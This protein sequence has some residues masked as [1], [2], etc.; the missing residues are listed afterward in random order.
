MTEKEFMKSSRE[1]KK[2]LQ[3]NGHGPVFI[4]QIMYHLTDWFYFMKGK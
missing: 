1:Y 2:F 3:Q 4:S